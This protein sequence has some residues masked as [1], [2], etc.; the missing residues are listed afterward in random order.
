MTEPSVMLKDYVDA[1][2]HE[3]AHRIDEAADE[4][5]LIRE[6][7]RHLVRAETFQIAVDR[8]S[9]LERMVSRLY[10]GLAVLVALIAVMGVIAHYLLG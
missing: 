4:R 10:G 5:A 9:T 3:L 2:D 1:R 6:D 7:L 8:I